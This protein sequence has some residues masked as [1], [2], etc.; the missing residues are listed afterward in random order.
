MADAQT[1]I[2]QTNAGDKLDLAKIE[3]A[4]AQDASDLRQILRTAKIVGLFKMRTEASQAAA[5]AQSWFK[6]LSGVAVVGTAIATLTSGL[7]L[8]GAGS[9]AAAAPTVEGLVRW[10]KDN[11]NYI[12]GVQIAALFFSAVVTSVLASQNFVERWQEQRKQAERLRQQIFKDILTMAQAKVPKPLPA[13]D[14]GNPIAQAFEF[15]RRYQHEMQINFYSKGAAR[16]GRAAQRLGWLTAILAGLAAI[17]GVLGGFGSSALVVSAFLGIAVPIL[18]S[19]AQSWRVSSRDSD[20]IATYQKAKAAL[21]TNLLD[22]DTVRA[23]AASGD[24]AAVGDYVNKVHLIMST[25]NDA[26]SPAPKP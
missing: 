4:V 15:F 12:L 7:L 20:S 23:C 5:S 11:H 13:P 25:E 16:H 1:W 2:G 17:T 26:W 19:A 3:A 9:E 24:A 6:R 8:Y 22:I 18:L 21:D 10:V 14:P